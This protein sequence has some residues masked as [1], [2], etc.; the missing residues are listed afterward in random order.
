MNSGNGKAADGDA[1][2]NMQAMPLVSVIISSYNHAP[3]IEEA[4]RSV[5][6]QTYPKIE[7]LVIDD[8]SSD[9]SVSRIE[10]LQRQFGFDF[11]AQSNKGLVPTLNEA[12]ARARGEFIAPFGS[13]DIMLPDRLAIQVAHM[14]HAEDNVGI[15]AGNVEM[16]DAQGNLL[17]PRRQKCHPARRLDFDSLFLNS[18]PGAPTPTLL[19]RRKAIEEVGGFDPRVKIED[20]FIELKITR[21]GYVIDVLPEVLAQ[22]RIHGTNTYKNRR[23]MIETELAVYRHFSDHPAYA[24]VCRNY[25]NAMFVKVAA[26]DKALARD[27]L[28]QMPLRA[29]NLKTL[30]GLYRYL[31]KTG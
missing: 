31:C 5:L 17:P 26:K 18:C 3:Y 9:D 8:G 23:L 6:N 14:L 27:L 15:C 30:K 24:R 13:D 10:R 1:A 2:G 4:I 16:I 21:S 29:Y 28:K 22:Y 25:L 11:R 12:V 19:F 7:L 20:L